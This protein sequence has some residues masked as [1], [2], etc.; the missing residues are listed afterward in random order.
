MS[1]KLC[2]LGVLYKKEVSIV[3]CDKMDQAFC[4][5]FILQS[6]NAQ[7][8]GTRLEVYPIQNIHT[9]SCCCVD[10]SLSHLPKQA[11]QGHILRFRT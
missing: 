5:N 4:M 8:L 9:S 11:L 10:H 1:R 3:S 2:A 6:T 7:V